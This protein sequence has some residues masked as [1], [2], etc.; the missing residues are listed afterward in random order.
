MLTIAVM[1]E[2]VRIIETERQRGEGRFIRFRTNNYRFR[3][4]SDKFAIRVPKA[5]DYG[6]LSTI[7]KRT[8]HNRFPST[9]PR[10]LYLQSLR[11]IHWGVSRD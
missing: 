8:W 9:H 6:S 7:G 4:M 2:P 5:I 11:H 10:E 3:G 1:Y